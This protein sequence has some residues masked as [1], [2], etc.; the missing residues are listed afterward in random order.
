[1]SSAAVFGFRLSADYERGARLDE[2]IDQTFTCLDELLSLGADPTDALSRFAEDR[3]VRIMTVPKCNGLEFDTTVILGVEN[4]AFWVLVPM[5]GQPFL[6]HTAAPVPHRRRVSGSPRSSPTLGCES[7][8]AAGFHRLRPQDQID[9]GQ[10]EMA[11]TVPA[12]RCTGATPLLETTRD[13]QHRH[14]DTL[15]QP[16]SGQRPQGQ[17]IVKGPYMPRALSE[18]FDKVPRRCA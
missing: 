2:I 18:P 17:C 3:V 15:D 8:A 11:T 1:M 7:L 14:I 13:L 5:N 6:P 10:E 4:Q 9:Q 16:T 12:H